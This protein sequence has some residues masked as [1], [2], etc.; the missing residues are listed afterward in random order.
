MEV[1][2]IDLWWMAKPIA[3]GHI[4]GEGGDDDWLVPPVILLCIEDGYV[5]S[6]KSSHYVEAIQRRKIRWFPGP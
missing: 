4:D 5:P 3:Q 6:S 2:D 1:L